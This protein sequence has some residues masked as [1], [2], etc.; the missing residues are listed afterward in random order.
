MNRLCDPGLMRLFD[1]AVERRHGASE[2][3]R[4][5][6]TLGPGS[7]NS[8]GCPAVYPPNPAT[9]FPRR[10]PPHPPALV[11]DQVPVQQP[12]SDQS[13][14]DVAHLIDGVH[15]ADVVSS[16]EGIDVTL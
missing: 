12:L 2:A 11:G 4:P 1:Q 7:A 14:H 16:G 15:L 9:G 3:G 8:S 10:T 13:G 5:A 6:Q